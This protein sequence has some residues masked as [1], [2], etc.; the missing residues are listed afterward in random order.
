[1]QNIPEVKT[2]ILA[3]SR[4]CFPVEL[5][6]KRRQAV[7]AAC[8]AK[9]IPLIE[10]ETIVENERD[11]LV[12]LGELDSKGANA[13]VVYLGNFG[14]EG[15]LTMLGEQFWGPVMLA[16][17]AEESLKDLFGG[18]GDAYCGML[19]AS[20]NCALRSMTPHIPDYPVGMPDDI[21]TPEMARIFAAFTK[22]HKEVRLDVT[23]GLRACLVAATPP[24]A[25][26]S[27]ITSPP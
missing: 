1:M 20:Y 13:L 27:F 14:P 5:S 6:R 22:R 3:V 4:D 10:C 18:R 2:A 23:T 17:A 16:G 25:S 11:M 19:N 26:I 12:A 15:P 7:A 21:A 9:N 24:Q 8:R